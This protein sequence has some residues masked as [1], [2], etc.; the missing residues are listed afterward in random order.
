MATS[1]AFYAVIWTEN[2]QIQTRTFD[3]LAKARSFAFQRFGA[4]AETGWSIERRQ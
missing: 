3:T 1:P 2:D 4:G